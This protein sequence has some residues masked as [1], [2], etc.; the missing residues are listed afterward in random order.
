VLGV[1]AVSVIC[2][3]FKWIRGPH[4][5]TPFSPSDCQRQPE[6]LLSLGQVRQV[7]DAMPWLQEIHIKLLAVDSPLMHRVLDQ[8][9]FPSSLTTLQLRLCEEEDG[10]FSSAVIEQLAVYCRALTDL[11]FLQTPLRH[12]RMNFSC[13]GEVSPAQTDVLKQLRHLRELDCSSLTQDA[14]LRLCEP[15]PTAHGLQSL[16]YIN[17]Y[18]V[19]IP[20]ACMHALANL[21]ALTSFNTGRMDSDCFEL[22]LPCMP[23]LRI[24]RITMG[25]SAECPAA[26]LEHLCHALSVLPTLTSLRLSLWLEERRSTYWMERFLGAMGPRL[27]RLTLTPLFM[28]KPVCSSPGARGGGAVL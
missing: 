14:L 9:L 20:P 16:E 8:P 23:R 6:L 4:C 11:T 2:A 12:F 18:P 7:R 26:H 10:Q 27:K 17:L 1:A 5:G 19:D 15:A 13:G 21:P 3:L 28:R 22:I 25:E 24:M